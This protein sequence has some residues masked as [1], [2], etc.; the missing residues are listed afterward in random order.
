MDECARV[1]TGRGVEPGEGGDLEFAIGRDVAGRELSPSEA[2]GAA[3]SGGRGQ[4]IEAPQRGSRV[5]SCAAP[6]RTGACVGARAGEVQRAG[7]RAVWADVGRR[8]SGERR[9]RH[10]PSRHVAAVDVDRGIVESRPQTRAPSPATGAQGAFRRAGPAG[11]QF[12]L[13][14]PGA[15][16]ARLLDEPGRRC[17]RP[18]ARAARG[19]GND[20]GGG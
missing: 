4:G 17:H 12:P 18:D 6:G 3:V 8:A 11:W 5:E 14:G 1:V 13:A 7:G 19:R 10:R 20:L 16:A 2:S 9:R 15:R